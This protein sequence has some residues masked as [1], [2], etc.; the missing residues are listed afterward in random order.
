MIKLASQGQGKGK[1]ECE[2]V[3][4]K[5]VSDRVGGEMRAGVEGSSSGLYCSSEHYGQYT[6][7]RLIHNSHVIERSGACLQ[8]LMFLICLCTNW[9]PWLSTVWGVYVYACVCM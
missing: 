8:A 4:S 5:H 3:G 7:Q 2:E 9:N 6:V 1:Y